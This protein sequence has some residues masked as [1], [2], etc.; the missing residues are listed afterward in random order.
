MYIFQMSTFFGYIFNVTR[1]PSGAN[2]RTPLSANRAGEYVYSLLLIFSKMN[3]L[4]D[5]NC[6]IV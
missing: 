5:Q 6:T 2:H 1:K 3:S 4:F